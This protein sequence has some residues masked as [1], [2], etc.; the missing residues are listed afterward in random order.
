MKNIFKF[1][2]ILLITASFVSCSDEDSD[3][4]DD[5]NV[6][7]T[8][9]EEAGETSSELIGTWEMISFEFEGTSSTGSLGLTFV[10]DFEGVGQNIDYTIEITEDE[11][12]ASGSYD[13]E[14][15]TTAFGQTMTIVESLGDVSG[16]STYTREG[17]TLFSDGS[18]VSIG[19]NAP[20]MS[21][22]GE[23]TITELTETTLRLIQEDTQEIENDGVT[24]TVTISVETVL[25]RL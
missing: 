22:V 11:F 9:T 19:D 14:L 3:M 1:L 7:E 17:N 13:V 15:T 5:T 8:E 23:A 2:L 21:M 16:N 6:V 20:I 25:N 4:N 12:I 10:I 24:S 18:F